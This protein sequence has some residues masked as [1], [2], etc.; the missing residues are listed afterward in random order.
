[1]EKEEGYIKKT[2]VMLINT[3]VGNAWKS[4]ECIFKETKDGETIIVDL[5]EEN[6]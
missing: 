3:K 1:M 6:N 4:D 5:K 2:F